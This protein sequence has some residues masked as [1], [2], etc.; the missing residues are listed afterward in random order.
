MKEKPK[1]SVIVVNFN[2][3]KFVL[4]CLASIY[5]GN[6]P[7]DQLEVLVVDNASKDKTIQNLT[8]K[9]PQIK[10]ILNKINLGFAK[11]NNQGIKESRGDY[12]LLLNPDTLVEVNT[13][14]AMV[15]FM[16][17]NNQVGIS[18]CQVVLPSGT[19]D[20]ACHRGYPTP[21]R[22]FCHFSGLAYLFPKSTIINGYH[23]G[24]QDIEKVHEVESVAGAFMF[25]RRKAG[26]DVGWLD[27]DYFWY[28][29]DL[30]F[31][32]KVKK[33][34]WK[35]MFVPSVKILHYKGISGGIK[36]HSQIDSTADKETQILATRSRFAVMRIFY[37]KHYQ[38]IYPQ[39]ITWIVMNGIKMREYL[40]LLKYY[41]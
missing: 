7:R 9:Y 40:S 34:G 22:A 25:I 33:A 26:S 19:L 12:I 18:T 14:T 35:I 23:L 39:W 28:G 4:D 10:L 32:Y 20:D 30:D 21:W 31:C 27:E 1:I 5:N 29:E 2:T 13:M 38:G 11:A 3:T 15:D 8:S 41:F 24:Y 36:K 17:R 37:K 16:D 6:F